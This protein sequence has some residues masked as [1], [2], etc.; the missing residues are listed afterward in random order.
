MPRYDEGDTPESM[1]AKVEECIRGTN[2][3]LISLGGFGGYVTFGFDHSVVNVHD[4]LDFKILGNAF[5]TSSN[6]NASALNSG[7]SAEP[8]IVMV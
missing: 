4:S 5:Y 8:G 1:R 2:D 6:P 3:E 7:G